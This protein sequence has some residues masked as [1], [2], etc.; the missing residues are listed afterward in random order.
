[1]TREA[2]LRSYTIWAA[3]ALFA[4]KECGSIEPG[5]RADFAVLDRDIMK[6][7]VEDIL[8]I[9]VLRTILNG[10]TVYSSPHSAGTGSCGAVLQ[11]N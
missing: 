9:K 3:E 2:A 4:E 11:G 1:M 5:K 10:E 7:P 6:V 8:K